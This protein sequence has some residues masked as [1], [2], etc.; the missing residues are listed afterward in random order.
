MNIKIDEYTT[1]ESD[2]FN[3]ILKERIPTKNNTFRTAK[4]FFVK[5]EHVI[6]YLF[7]R[8]VKASS[9]STVDEL[10]DEISE[11]KTITKKKWRIITSELD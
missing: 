9:A 11:I 7:E 5:I 6:A 8:E 2:N 4:K 3:Y 1:L 10:A